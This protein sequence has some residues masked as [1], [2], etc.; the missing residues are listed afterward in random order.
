VLYVANTI[1]QQHPRGSAVVV[2]LDSWIGYD[3]YDGVLLVFVWAMV[4]YW[5]GMVQD[6]Y[7]DSD[8]LQRRETVQ[9]ALANVTLECDNLMARVLD[10]ND[11][12]AHAILDQMLAETPEFAA[13]SLPE[14]IEFLNSVA[15][16]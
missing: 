12:R 1:N 15:T 9:N 7:D 8:A 16:V 13:K 6:L 14:I 3:E 11:A 10:K 5:Y 2:S 4:W